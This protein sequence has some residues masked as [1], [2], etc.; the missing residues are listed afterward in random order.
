MLRPL[1]LA[2][3]AALVCAAPAAAAPPANDTPAGATGFSPYVAENGTPTEL[4]AVADLAGAT[5]DTGLARCLGPGSFARTVWFRVP[6]A[7]TPQE[8][9][10]EGAGRTLDPVDLAA[11][12]DGGLG[13]EEPNACADPGP[14]D[15][16]SAALALR[17]PAG[18]DVLI[19]VGRRGSL[20]SAEDEQVQL[21]LRTTPLDAV[22]EPAGDR[23][24]DAPRVADG[25]VLLGGAT[26]TEEDPAQPECPSLGTVWRKVVPG[27]S[28]MRTIR[29]SGAAVGTLTAFSG[30][31]PIDCVNRTGRGALALRARVVKGQ[32]LYVRLGTDR[33][34]ADATAKLEVVR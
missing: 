25:R 4:Q 32:S 23:R 20:M 13:P 14:I 18:R 1:P 28:G 21:W 10:V 24:G 5:A 15:E 33:P 12:V 9:H 30:G 7:D 16:P 29:V 27:R 17:V 19:Q 22:D 2:V 34:A 6:A 31:E 8:I 3:A 26:I 11:F